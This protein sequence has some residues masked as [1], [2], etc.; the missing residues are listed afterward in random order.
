MTGD[1]RKRSASHYGKDV[2]RFAPNF[3]VY[4]LP[5]DVV[6]LYSED[7]KFF[8]HGP[9]Y[10]ALARAIA[11]GEKS[12]RALVRELERD[13]PSDQIREA[14]KRLVDRRFILT[15]PPASP[16]GAAAAYWASL[17]LSP[18]TAEKNLKNFPVR[19]RSMNVQGEAQLAAA[20]RTFGVRVGRRSAKLT[21]TLVSDYLDEQLA[22][23]NRQHLSDGTPWL[24]VQPSGIFPLVGPV[25]RPGDSACWACLGE[26]MQ[27]NREIKALIARLP[28]RRLTASPL[29]R[30]ML[31]Q[32][33]IELAAV[34]IAKTI[35]P[36]FRTA[37]ADHIISLDLLG[38]TTARHYVPAR[39]QCPVCG[40][41]KLR[42][43][44][45]APAP[46]ELGE[47]GKLLMTSGG[48]R[49]VSARDT[50][51]RFGKHWCP[52]TGVDSRLERR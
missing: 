22:E 8:L 25:L 50:V 36:E 3:T 46:I 48:Y 31:G 28:A 23:L 4:V 52:I 24:L 27:R 17:G 29:A 34:E 41:K 11:A 40:Q 39:P 21:V 33:G 18:E 30:D 45:R 42:D 19:I 5:H 12:S 37:L 44:R 15:K 10:C 7:R 9:L 20:L 1:R 38:A 47:G 2:P 6:C 35:A 13:F 14:L 49:T 32:S 16:N 26:R 51:A 43:P